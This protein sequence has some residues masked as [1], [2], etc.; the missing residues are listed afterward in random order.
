ME[1][2]TNH[3]LL[4]RGGLTKYGISSKYYPD[5]DIA[6]LSLETAVSIYHKDYWLEVGCS[7]Y[8]DPL[9]IVMFDTAVNCGVS[10]TARWL[11]T[12]LGECGAE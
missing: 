9:A 10:S 4:D 5:L 11:Q 12:T 8:P 3:H 6:N 1:G 2:G 7:H